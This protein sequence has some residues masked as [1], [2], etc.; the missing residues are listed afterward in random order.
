MPAWGGK[1]TGAAAGG[2]Q[3]LQGDGIAASQEQGT[4]QDFE[5][6]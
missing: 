5:P 6:E 3:S 1:P 4:S 2:M